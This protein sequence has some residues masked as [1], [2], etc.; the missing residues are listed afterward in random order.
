MT[1]SRSEARSGSAERTARFWSKV[2]MAGPYQ[3]WQ[4][5]GTDNGNGY[6]SFA[7]SP[8]VNVPA[9]RF[10]YELVVGP[11]PEGK[12]IDHLC[13]NRGCV[14]P[15]HLEAVTPKENTLRGIGPTAVNARKTH[16]ARGHPFENDNLQ[17]RPQGWRQCKV[18]KAMT[19]NRVRDNAIPPEKK[20][21]RKNVSR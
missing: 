6:G 17:I 4:W 1:N 15:Q 21:P 16:C 9:H 5:A 20:R 8:G 3:C 13:R 18:C 2:T 14:N 7:V 10:A 12:H 11:I 19:H